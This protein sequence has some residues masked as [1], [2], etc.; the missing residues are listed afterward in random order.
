MTSHPQDRKIKLYPRKNRKKELIFLIEIGSRRKKHWFVYKVS[1][2]LILL[3][4]KTIV[5]MIG[6]AGKSRNEYN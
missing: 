6:N 2:I 5:K 1:S 3:R 4:A